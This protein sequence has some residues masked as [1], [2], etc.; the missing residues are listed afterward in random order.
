MRPALKKREGEPSP[1]PLLHRMTLTTYLE[2][3]GFLDA[4]TAAA[5]IAAG[6][7][8]PFG[9]DRAFTAARLFCRHD[10][11]TVEQQV[12]TAEEIGRQADP[13]M[14]AR[15]ARLARP[16][17]PVR[18]MGVVNV[19]P[20]S[21]SDGGRW[22]GQDAA[23][24]HGLALAKAG[25][26]ILDVGG[27]STRPGALAVTAQDEIARIVGVV[28]GLA[29]QGLTVSVDTRNARTMAAALEAGAR[30]VNDVTALRHDPEAMRVVAAAGCPVVLMHS[31][32]DP[33]TMQ[34][35]PRY[36][37]ACLDVFDHLEERVA[38]CEAAGI[39]RDR[40]TLDPGLGFG[41]RAQHSLD[42]LQHL[43]LLRTLGC[44]ILVGASRKSMIAHVMA[45]KELAPSARV[46]GSL[47]LALAGVQR[48]ASIARVHDVA[49][50]RQALALFQAVDSTD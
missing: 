21:F 28:R 41:K 27:E 36:R 47:A 19:T 33:R 44:E 15:L 17:G 5:A 23:I 37:R 10:D 8:L 49:E 26:Q 42:V 11:D 2:P 16:V 40:I 18:I 1:A 12:L 39:S 13:A 35:D 20:D 46:P 34:L 50:T 30:I 45:D 22:F 6:A 31:Q 25:A 43:A 48:G 38:A 32:G 3:L 7:A 4:G 24:E 29:A 9:A 14:Q